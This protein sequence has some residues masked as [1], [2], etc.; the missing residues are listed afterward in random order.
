MSKGQM[1]IQEMA[2][3]LITI[4]IFF[5]MVALVYSSIRLSSLRE[6]VGSLREEAAKELVKKLTDIPEFSWTSP[7]CSGCVDLDKVLAMKDMPAY[8]GFWDLDYL[9]VETVYP[10]KTK[11]E[12]TRANYPECTTITLVN[13][14]QYFGSPSTAFVALCRI[15][16]GKGGYTKCEMGKIHAASKVIKTT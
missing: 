2:F 15:E 13:N 4:I 1:K 11:V 6:D 7:T 3:V 5:A 16:P 8:R 12:C 9:M 10:N 14:T